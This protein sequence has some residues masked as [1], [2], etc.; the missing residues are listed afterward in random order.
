MELL[1]TEI[2]ELELSQ[3]SRYVCVYKDVDNILDDLGYKGA[4]RVLMKD[5]ILSIEDAM[6]EGF[7]NNKCVAIPTVGRLMKDIGKI[8]VKR[9][10]EEIDSI[11]EKEDRLAAYIK[12][13]EIRKETFA[14]RRKARKED[15]FPEFKKK[16]IKKW[17]E[18]AKAHNATY[19]NIYFKVR[20]DG[21]LVP[22]DP[23]LE[24]IYE[25]FND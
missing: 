5:I 23:E 7:K 15:D 2:E 20:M 14:A 16:H 13:V 17:L 9:R 11:A 12:T 22:F 4:D 21:Q 6:L 18:V 1:Q 10:K 19:A 3:D 24:D 8:E 25:R